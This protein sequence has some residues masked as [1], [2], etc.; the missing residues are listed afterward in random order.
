M[1]LKTNG[2]E[3]NYDLSG[4]QDGPVVVLSHSLGSSLVN[5]NLQMDV[6]EPHFR[7]LRYDTRGH[8]GTEAPPG[9]YTLDLLAR[10]LTGLLDALRIDKVH[11]VGL[12]M[13]GMI[14]QCL[15]LHHRPLLRSLVLCDT[16]AVV[17]AEA[18]PVWQERIDLARRQGVQALL[19]QTMERWFTPEFLK[20]NPPILSTIKKQFLA[21]PLEGYVGCG[22]AI[23]RLNYIDRLS[24][25][26]LP[27][28]II[29]GEDDPAT[30]VAGSKAIHERIAHSRLVILPSARHLGNVER[31]EEFNGALIA[32][33]KE[34]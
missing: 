9:P 27:T 3:M 11:F 30:P 6:L 17:P 1:R 32:F 16:A 24:E 5:W 19:D 10:D 29:V 4:K 15:A 33:L 26:S 28:L 25:I 20:R 7:V 23:R 2:I 31:A 22:E 12:S 13:G 8:G 14:G 21:T 18:Q 34:Q